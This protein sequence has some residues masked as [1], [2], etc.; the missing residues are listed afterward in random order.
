MSIW[1]E[2]QLTREELKITL[3]ES[4]ELGEKWAASKAKYETVKAKQTLEYKARGFAATIIEKII[5]GDKLVNEAM[6]Q[7]DVA[8]VQYDNSKEAINILKKDYDY[9]REQYQ[10]E[11][12]QSGWRD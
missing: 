1:Q 11:W 5:K 8:Q 2:I 4:K 9:L 10:R 6:Y 3:Q 12:T 7:M